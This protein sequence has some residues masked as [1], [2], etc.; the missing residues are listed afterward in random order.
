MI[1]MK[2]LRRPEK[3]LQ[4]KWRKVSDYSIPNCPQDCCLTGAKKAW[5]TFY[6]KNTALARTQMISTAAHG[7]SRYAVLGS[8]FCNKAESNYSPTEGKFTALTDALG[9]TSYF[10]LGCSDL[11]IRAL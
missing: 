6:A 10:T 8:R 1:L 4:T 9:K 7:A 11:T 3:S 2:H 5:A